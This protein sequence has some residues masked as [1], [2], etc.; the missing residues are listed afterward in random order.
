MTVCVKMDD[1]LMEVYM[2]LMK[3]NNE[4]VQELH[5]YYAYSMGKLHFIKE[6]ER[7]MEQRFVSM[8]PNEPV[9]DEFI[10]MCAVEYARGI[11]E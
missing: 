5:E 2:W 7:F 4:S 9:D 8:Y 11:T 6:M 10:H 1:F 3:P